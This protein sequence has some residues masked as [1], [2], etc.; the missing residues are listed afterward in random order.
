MDLGS[1]SSVLSFNIL[2]GMFM[3]CDLVVIICLI[4]LQMFLM[5]LLLVEK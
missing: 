3:G 5:F 4:P 1:F 2:E